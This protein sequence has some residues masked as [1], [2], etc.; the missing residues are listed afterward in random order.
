MPALVVAAELLAK[1]LP[2]NTK[3]HLYR[4]VWE[5]SS[6]KCEWSGVLGRWRND[7]DSVRCE[8]KCYFQLLYWTLYSTVV[9][10]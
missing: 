10:M 7:S 1:K 3:V 9:T 8:R 2:A 4:C 5:F 6:G